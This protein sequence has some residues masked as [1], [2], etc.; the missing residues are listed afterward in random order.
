MPDESRSDNEEVDDDYEEEDGDQD[1]DQYGDWDGR[2][3]IVCPS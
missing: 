3:E 2:V 1:V